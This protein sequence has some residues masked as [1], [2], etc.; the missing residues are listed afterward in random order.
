MQHAGNR[1]QLTPLQLQTRGPI[2]TTNSLFYG[3]S[4]I[5]AKMFIA[6]CKMQQKPLV[7]THL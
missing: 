4:C 5:F 3:L 2:G 1:E 6:I 7:D